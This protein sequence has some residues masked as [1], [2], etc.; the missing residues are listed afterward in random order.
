MCLLIFKPK[1]KKI[2]SETVLRAAAKANPDGFGF[3]TP[4]KYMRSL[5]FEAFYKN[6]K[7]VK[8]DEPCIIHARLA[9]HGSIKKNNCHPFRK[10]GISFAH[11]GI[12][13]IDPIG[14]KTD[15]ETAFL[16]Y[17]LPAVKHYG[18]YSRE[19]SE[20][21]NRIIGG[22]KFAIIDEN[23]ESKL[24]G[25]FT[26]LSDGNFYSNLRWSYYAYNRIAV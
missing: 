5:D 10:D 13:D 7:K 4:D 8:V 14:D 20:V 18:L 25:D 21:V 9:T 15:S 1:G 2:P 3:A 22:S 23:G 12:L 11:N 17:I 26:R 16:L 19:V 6:L 24:F